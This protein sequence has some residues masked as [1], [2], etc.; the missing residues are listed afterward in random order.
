MERWPLERCEK[1]RYVVQWFYNGEWKDLTNSLS[2]QRANQICNKERRG[3]DI[4]LPSL[5]R[6][7]PAKESKDVQD[8]LNSSYLSSFSYSF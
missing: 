3:E 5:I 7:I 8:F 2:F 4:N 1:M 6:I